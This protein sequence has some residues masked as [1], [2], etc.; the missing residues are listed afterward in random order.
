MTM[1]GRRRRAHDKLA[2]LL[3]AFYIFIVILFVH[4]PKAATDQ[5]DMLNIFRNTN[6]IGGLLMYAA[7]FARDKR[8]VG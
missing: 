8:F 3:T 4:A 5:M 2:A 6:M 1:N 7:A